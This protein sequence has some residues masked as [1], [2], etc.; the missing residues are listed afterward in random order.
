MNPSATAELREEEA[1]LRGRL[2]A[3]AE[4]FADGILTRAQLHTATERIR[5]RL[6]KI[7]PQLYGPD[8]R[9]YFGDVLDADDPR[10]AF[11]ALPQDRK[12]ELIDTMVTVTIM[13]CGRGGN[14]V[15]DPLMVEIVGR[16]GVICRPS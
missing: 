10:D 8:P 11:R 16:N 13:P 4:E 9:R 3:L 2:Q 7:E 12:R 14:K 6:T 15:F 5:K 1:A